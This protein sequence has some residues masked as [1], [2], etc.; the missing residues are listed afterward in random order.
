MKSRCFLNGECLTTK[1][2]Y[3]VD[4]SNDTNRGKKVYFGLVDTPFEKIYK[5]HTRD[6][7]H[8]KYGRAPNWLNIFGN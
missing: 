8:E 7:K 6:F 1:M 3:R 2:F 5:N 4:V